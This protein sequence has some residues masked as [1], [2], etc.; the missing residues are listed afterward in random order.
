MERPIRIP[1]RKE[2]RR[3]VVRRDVM[4]LHAVRRV[5]MRN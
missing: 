3:S 5:G 4:R 1:D 2:T